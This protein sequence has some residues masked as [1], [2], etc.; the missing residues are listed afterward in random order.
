MPNGQADVR[1]PLNGIH[2]VRCALAAAAVCHELSI[3]VAQIASAMG[4]AR[5]SSGRGRCINLTNGIRLIDDTY[6]SNPEA[7]VAA[8]EAM[9]VHYQGRKFVIAGEMAELGEFS[10]SLHQEA[11]RKIAPRIDQL[12]C[13]GSGA[14]LLMKGAKSVRTLE[15]KLFESTIEVKEALLSA[16]KPNDV[17][18]I[19]GSR[20]IHLELIV[21]YLVDSLGV[22]HS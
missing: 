5:P 12:W 1:L 18:L 22:A 21:G 14:A 4:C 17:I 10:A 8:V 6:N 15:G 11:G 7:L 9:E 2:S 19:K 3:G 13:V 16:I 20:K